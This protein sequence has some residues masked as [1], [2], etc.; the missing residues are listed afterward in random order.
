M[1]FGPFQSA[2]LID[3]YGNLFPQV[4]AM[5]KNMARNKSIP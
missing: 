1:R 3:A 5:Y 2:G 4:R